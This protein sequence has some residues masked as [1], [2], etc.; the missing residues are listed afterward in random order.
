[1]AIAE[2]NKFV[3]NQ[4]TLHNAFSPFEAEDGPPLTD[5]PV[6]NLCKQPLSF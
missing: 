1:M 5:I 6:D 2:I 3:P 4:H